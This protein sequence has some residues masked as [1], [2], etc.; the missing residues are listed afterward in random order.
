MKS[1][2]N[3]RK[4]QNWMLQL[5]AYSCTIEHIKGTDN[6]IADMLSRA[7]TC[8]DD[9]ENIKKMTQLT[10]NQDE[11]IDIDI[12]DYTYHVQTLNSGNFTPRQFAAYKKH[13]QVDLSQ[14]GLDLD[15][16]KEQGK[17]PEIMGILND[18]KQKKK[19]I[20]LRYIRQEGVLYYLS[21]PHGE[22]V[23]RLFVPK[24]LRLGLIEAYHNDN[25]HFGVDKC[26][27]TLARSYYWPNM[28]QDLWEYINKCVRCNQRNLKKVR[29]PLKETKFHLMHLLK[30][31]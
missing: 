24:Q 15:M 27:H 29:L 21:D 2:S 26:Y 31:H 10:D 4:I 8:K 5:A 23:T 1:P 14:P 17:D 25:G 12:P 13:E 11:E 16:R 7:P 19:G 20:K 9:G 28:F 3:N 22:A 18:L 30:S 6:T